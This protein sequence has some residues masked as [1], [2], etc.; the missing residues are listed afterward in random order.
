MY[1]SIRKN[2][3]A[4][5]SFILI[6]L[7]AYSVAVA[8]LKILEERTLGSI[9]R[10]FLPAIPILFLIILLNL[11]DIKKISFSSF[12]PTIPSNLEL[13]LILKRFALILLL[14]IPLGLLIYQYIG[15][16]GLLVGPVI[17]FLLISMFISCFLM[18]TERTI[19]GVLIFIAAIPFLFF[20]QGQLYL[21]DLKELIISEITI[22]FSAIFLLIISI[23]FFMVQFQGN[24]KGFSSEEKK[25]LRLCLFFVLLPI[26]SIIFSKDSFHSFIFYVM[27]LVLP[28][29]FFYILMRSI[30]NV[31]DIKKLIFA[32]VIAAFLYEFFALYFMYQQAGVSEITTGIYGSKIHTG[33]STTVFPLIVPFQI[34]MYNLLKGWKRLAVVFIIIISFIYIFLSNYRTAI[35]ASFIAFLIFFYFYYRTSLSKKLVLTFIALLFLVLFVS[36]IENITEKLSFFRPIQTIQR[37]AA[38][39]SLNRILSNRLAISKAA[40]NMVHDHPFLGIGPDMW[41]QYIPHYSLTNYYQNIFNRRIR[42]YSYDPHNL[43][44]LV[45]LNYGVAN[46]I[47]YLSILFIAVRKGLRNVKES[48]S[49]LIRT[50]SLGI[51]ISLI[52][53]IIM[54][55][56]TIRFFNHS[57]LLYAI[58]FWSIIAIIFKLGKFSLTQ[59]EAR[60]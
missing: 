19:F 53:W 7:F 22:P 27:D 33:F 52:I 51:F 5:I 24:S 49:V 3:K 41:S 48:S 57:I 6:S 26:F 44:L 55:F 8:L 35:A 36:Y 2:S 10:H 18:I 20:I 50:V 60:V 34:V 25:V 58:I 40:V 47:L 16:A 32:L 11:Y 30:K 46:F 39:E 29:I 17:V 31:E 37:V 1:L 54:S 15:D 43:Y 42:Y 9:F 12:I 28:L 4:F 38:K 21:M 13:D 45:W 23:F 56:F 14:V 59:K